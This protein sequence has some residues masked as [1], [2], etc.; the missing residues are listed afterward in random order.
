M[1]RVVVTGIGVVSPLGVGVEGAWDALLNG[2]SG[3]HVAAWGEGLP[4]QVAAT[5]P[6]IDEEVLRDCGASSTNLARFTKLGL[7]A[8][9]EALRG[10]GWDPLSMNR[11]RAGAV[12]GS[13]IGAMDEILEAQDTLDNRWVLSGPASCASQYLTGDTAVRAQ[14]GREPSQPALC[15]QGKGAPS[16]SL[17]VSVTACAYA[18]AHQHGSGSGCDPSPVA[19]SVYVASDRVCCRCGVIEHTSLNGLGRAPDLANRR[20]RAGAHAIADACRILRCGEADL[21]VA[22]ASE[23]ATSRLT[24]AGFRRARDVATARDT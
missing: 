20:G 23:S 15:A 4:S 3:V 13:G 18:G 11:A 9:T 8:A 22:G 16:P 2:S 10:A 17:R 6:A 7:V 1:R 12:I 19:G 24:V 21:M 14:Q 5:V